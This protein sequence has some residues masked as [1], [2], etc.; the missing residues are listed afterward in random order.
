MLSAPLKMLVD[1]NCFPN[2]I[3]ENLEEIRSKAFEYID[4]LRSPLLERESGFP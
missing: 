3:E 4:P 2:Q 1:S